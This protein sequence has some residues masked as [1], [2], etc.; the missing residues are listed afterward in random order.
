MVVNGLGEISTF[1]SVADL[2]K[3]DFPDEGLPMSP[4]IMGMHSCEGIKR[5]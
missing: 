3:V 4:I 2:K 1:A 5:F